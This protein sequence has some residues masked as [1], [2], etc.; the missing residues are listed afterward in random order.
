MLEEFSIKDNPELSSILNCMIAEINKISKKDRIE[1]EYVEAET[2]RLSKTK[3][4]FSSNYKVWYD[5]DSEGDFQVNITALNIQVDNVMYRNVDR[6][7]I[8]DDLRTGVLKGF[9]TI[10]VIDNEYNKL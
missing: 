6:I 2:D 5:Y 9:C 10:E 7:K 8:N 4:M 3:V 1:I